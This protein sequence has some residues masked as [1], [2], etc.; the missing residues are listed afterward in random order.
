MNALRTLDN[1][2]ATEQPELGQQWRGPIQDGEELMSYMDT[3]AAYEPAGGF[4]E[5][6]F[7]EIEAVSGGKRSA[8]GSEWSWDGVAVAA[9]TLSIAAGGAASIPSPATPAFVM[10][11]MT[12]GLVAIGAGWAASSGGAGTSPKLDSKE[13][14]KK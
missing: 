6:T 8:S 5:L 13:V 11:S 10:V 9:G 12:M 14:K 4:R 2:A 7:D 3:H 1:L